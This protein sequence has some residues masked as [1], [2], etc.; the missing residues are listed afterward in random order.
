M[1]FSGIVFCLSS[2]T[3]AESKKAVDPASILRATLHNGLRVVIVRNTLAPVVT[4][5][6]NYLAGSD[7]A[8]HGFP[9]TA[10]ALEHMM[11]RGSPG[12]SSQQLAAISAAM[13]GDNDAETQQTVTQYYFTVPAED[14]DIALRIEAIRMQTILC[15]DSL[16]DK[17]RGA[18]EQEVAQDLS[19]PSYVFLTKL[20]K[21]MFAGTPYALDALGTRES[22]DSTAASMLI[23]FHKEWYV[24]NNAILVVVGDIDPRKTLKKVESFFDGIPSGNLPARATFNFSEVKSA[25]LRMPTDLPYGLAV[26]SF[27][28]PGSDSPDYAAAQVLSDVLSSRRAALYSLVPEGKALSAEFD[29][30]PLPKSGIAF[31]LAAFPKGYDAQKLISR[32]KDILA[33]ELG[34]GVSADLVEAAKRHKISAQ[35]FQKN[36]IAGLASA[37]SDA[38]AVDGKQSP[39]ENLAA[40]SK[41]TVEDVN[42]VA[43]TFIDSNHSIIA[44]LTP[45][46]SGGQVSSKGFGGAESFTVKEAQQVALPAWA[47]RALREPSIPRSTVH[48]TVTLLPNGMKLLV[49]PESITTAVMLFG[50]IKNNVTIQQPD[51]KEGAADVLDQLFEYG[52]KNLDRVA[53]VKSADSIGADESAG[54]NFS[55][56]VLNDSFRKGVELLADNELSPALPLQAFQTIRQQTAAEVSGLLESPDYLTRRAILAA[57]LPKNDPDLREATPATVGTLA[58]S[59]E[60]TYYANVFRPDMTTVVVIGNA[61]PDTV[62]NIVW[63][64]FK[65]WKSSGPKPITDLPPV[66]LNKP[67]TTV[68]PD[69][70][71]VQDKVYL[72]EAS[73]IMRSDP[74][75]YALQLGNQILGGTNFAARLYRDVRENE[76]L[77]YYIE[78]KFRVLKNRGTFQVSYACDPDKVQRARALIIRDLQQMREVEVT[79]Q[80]LDQAKALLIRQIPLSESNVTDIAQGIIERTEQDL[81]LD[82]PILAAK[83]Y[84]KIRPRDIKMAFNKWIH[85]ENLATVIEGPS[86]K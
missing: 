43:R 1:L 11:F 68:V 28:F 80:E 3:G 12:L 61:N 51:G 74:D 25:T 64:Y 49:Q 71:S 58:L 65:N 17:E 66:P 6:I 35:E 60:K 39:E 55:L 86:P 32:M 37:W 18:I 79:R 83:R 14:L 75:Y 20:Y 10:H 15:T 78:S 50:S 76:G 48:P 16:W 85:P 56:Q 54:S 67:S 77:V 7:E 29:Y 84:K 52:S 33:K 13:G 40:V 45:Q 69:I 24:P 63:H 72:C 19:N 21:V 81:P 27:R 70:S 22:F 73:A 53:L 2:A 34:N 47:E 9:G 38:L 36:S 30:Y 23:K 46:A 8:P 26:L 44:V 41:V 57:I 4:T 62:K 82:E 5:E 31:A 59:D 42:R